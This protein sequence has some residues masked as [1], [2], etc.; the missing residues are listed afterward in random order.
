MNFGKDWE[1][2]RQLKKKKNEEKNKNIEKVYFD[3]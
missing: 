2:E 3:R 1:S